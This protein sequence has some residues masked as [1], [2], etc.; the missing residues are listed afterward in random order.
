[1]EKITFECEVITPMF[2]AGANGSTPELR[3]PSIKGAMRFWWRAMN[4]HLITWNEEKKHWDYTVLRNQEEELFGSSVEKVGKSKFS[5]VI[6]TD[7][8]DKDENEEL[9][10][11]EGKECFLPHHIGGMECQACK[12]NNYKGECKKGIPRKCF[13]SGKF[14]VKFIFKETKINDQVK[15]LFI[16][17]TILGGFGKRSRRGFGSIT[18]TGIEGKDDFKYPNTL[19]EIIKLMNSYYKLDDKTKPNKI[20]INNIISADY[21]FIK[22]IQCGQ[23]KEYT[24]LLE[25]I[26]KKTHKY[27]DDSLGYAKG[28]KRLGSPIY[29]S[30]I[31][32]ED[33]DLLPIITTLNTVINGETPSQNSFKEEILNGKQ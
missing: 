29:V 23:K 21:P 9:K 19:P 27:N 12:D 20:L 17:T 18:I 11:I 33:R 1:M 13:K 16:L 3:P 6:P 22:E 4:G 8:N 24:A 28:K 32:N 10:L 5:I 26:G 30:T 15:D 31:F 25:L 2:L 14:R 7:N